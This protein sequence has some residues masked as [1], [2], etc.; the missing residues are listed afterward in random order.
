MCLPRLLVF[1]EVKARATEDFGGPL[2]AVGWQKQR[3]VRRLAAIWLAEFRP[4][5]QFEVRFDVAA[6][7]GTNVSVIEAAF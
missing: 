5:G 2:A 7:V 1:C 6:V 3:R 4:T